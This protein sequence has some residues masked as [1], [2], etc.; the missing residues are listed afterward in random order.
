[1]DCFVF[2]L[3]AKIWDCCL[4]G[5]LGSQELQANQLSSKAAAAVSNYAQVAQQAW[6][7]VSDR[8]PACMKG[9][10]SRGRSD[11]Q[12]VSLSLFVKCGGSGQRTARV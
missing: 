7:R 10:F 4:C 6:Q 11:M 3:R 12:A 9:I 5:L 8:T 1:M 2:G